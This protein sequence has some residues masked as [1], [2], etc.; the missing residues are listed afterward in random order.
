MGSLGVEAP[1]PSFLFAPPP[2]GPARVTENF[3]GI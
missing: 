1:F 3:T 2:P